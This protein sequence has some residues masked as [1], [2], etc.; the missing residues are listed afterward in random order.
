M[1]DKMQTTEGKTLGWITAFKN[2]P[3]LHAQFPVKLVNGKSVP[4]VLVVCSKCGGS[5]SGD[6][7]HGRVSQS[8]PHVVTVSANGYCEPCNRMTHVDCRFRATGDETV[9]EWLS[10]NGYWQATELRQPS[11]IERVT[12]EA[13]NLVAWFNTMW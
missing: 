11:L 8:L 10:S 12:R 4:A 7:V 2:E 9:V 3:P 5:I 13:R 1:T 6:R